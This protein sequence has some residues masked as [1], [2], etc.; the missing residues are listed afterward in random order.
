MV[1]ARGLQVGLLD[2][3]RGPG[4]GRVDVALVEHHRVVAHGGFAPPRAEQ[5]RRLRLAVDENRR[6]PGLGG[7]DRL[8]QDDRHRLALVPDPVVGERHEPHRRGRRQ[9]GELRQ[10]RRGE[11]SDDP[12]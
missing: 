3:H 9:L 6:A 4:P 8:A 5:H 12:G 10:V 7:L 1:V 11:H 2:P